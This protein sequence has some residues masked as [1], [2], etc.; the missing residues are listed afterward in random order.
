MIYWEQ[1]RRGK[2]L[3]PLKDLYSFSVEEGIEYLRKVSM[4]DEMDFR[5]YLAFNVAD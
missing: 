4:S 3:L 5:T 1:Q 2:Y